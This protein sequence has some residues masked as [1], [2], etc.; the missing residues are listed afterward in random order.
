MLGN[1]AFEGRGRFI[2]AALGFH[3]DNLGSVLQDEVNLAVLI[4][5][6]PGRYW[7]LATQLL[8][9]IVF[10]QRPFELVIGFQE[11]RA[12]IDAGHMFEQ[13]GIEQE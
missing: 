12:V 4:R 3:R 7:E 11:D 9:E 6:I 8:Q 13:S 1:V 5:E 2:F 10:G